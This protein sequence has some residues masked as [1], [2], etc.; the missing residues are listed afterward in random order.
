MNARL[1][2]FNAMMSIKMID[3]TNKHR[4]YVVRVEDQE[5]TDL[6]ED[7]QIKIDFD[8]SYHPFT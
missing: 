7:T 5:P 1:K 8:Y 3:P 6:G 2:E 4:W